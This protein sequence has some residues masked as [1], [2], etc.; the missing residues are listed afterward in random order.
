[1]AAEEQHQQFV[2]LLEAFVA[3]RNR[4]REQVVAIEAEFAQRFDDDPR[5]ANLQY[6]LAMFGA[7]DNPGDAALVKECEWAL[8]VL[9]AAAR[10]P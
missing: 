7:D 2:Q 9:R 8:K 10:Q 3:G 1:M 4:S 6:E 5:F